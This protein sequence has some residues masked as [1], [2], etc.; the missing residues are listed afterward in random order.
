MTCSSR[1]PL[2]VSQ[3]IERALSVM[4]L[5]FAMRRFLKEV[6]Y[7]KAPVLKLLQKPSILHC[8]FSRSRFHLLL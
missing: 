3:V 5:K 8:K 1:E 7:I 4:D 2:C 6:K